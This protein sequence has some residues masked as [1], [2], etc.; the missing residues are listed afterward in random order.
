MLFG[1]SIENPPLKLKAK[2]VLDFTEQLD[3]FISANITL[4]QSLEK[5]REIYEEGNPDKPVTRMVKELQFQ[6][7]TGK[8]FSEA[9]SSF[10]DT[11]PRFYLSMIEAGEVSGNLAEILQHLKEYLKRENELREE[12]KGAMIYP[13]I[14]ITLAILVTIFLLTS[15]VPRFEKM[16]Q[17]SGQDLPIYTKILVEISNF[18]TSYQGLLLTLGLILG[19]YGLK[20]YIK[21]PAGHRWFDGWILKIPLLGPLVQKSAVA[22]FSLALGIL[23]HSKVDMLTVLAIGEGVVGNK[24]LEEAVSEA[25]L[26]VNVGENMSPS[27]RN[28]FPLKAVQ[29]LEVGENNAQLPEMA[30]SVSARYEKEVKDQL[31]IMTSLL[32]PALL[33]ILG[34]IVCF[35]ALAIYLPMLNALQYQ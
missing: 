35:V 28:F 34:A 30:L 31:K 22:R 12:I 10:P 33:V 21:T 7:I 13:L 4:D 20:N 27:L 15:I 26:R 19:F 29:M 11:F 18:L 5:L 3:S 23:L 1:K 32:E 16:L 24:I 8:K 14:V 17:S 9:L 2:D 6:V 25:T